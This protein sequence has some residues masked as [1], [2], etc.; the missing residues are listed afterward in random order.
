MI[1]VADAAGALEIEA[2]LGELLDLADGVGSVTI[3]ALRSASQG[4]GSTRTGSG[5]RAS[6]AARKTTSSKIIR[7]PGRIED[8]HSG[9]VEGREEA[10]EHERGEDQQ[11]VQFRHI[12]NSRSQLDARFPAKKRFSVEEDGLR[13]FVFLIAG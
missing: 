7:R 9:V 12:I 2:E 1:A 8:L 10:L 3:D 6:G 11:I 5:R 4:S 13:D